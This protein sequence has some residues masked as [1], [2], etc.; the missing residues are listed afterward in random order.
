MGCR[1]YMLVAV[2]LLLGVVP[3]Q[4][5]V[6]DEEVLF[7]VSPGRIDVAHRQTE[8]NCCSWIEFEIVQEALDIDIYEREQLESGGCDCYCCFDLAVALGGL[9][10]GDYTVRIWKNGELTGGVDVLLG[11]WVVPVEGGSPSLLMTAYIPC[12][13]SS[14][15]AEIDS[16]GMIKA[17]Y[18]D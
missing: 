13:A 1:S 14:G 15:T 18:G 17:L 2:A 10:P 7:E 12:A 16:W 11:E 8:Y 3:L 6:C 4:A 5:Q 9:E